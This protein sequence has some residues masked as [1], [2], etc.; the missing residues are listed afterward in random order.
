MMNICQDHMDADGL[1]LIKLLI[2][3]NR[4]QLAGEISEQ[5]ETKKT[6]NVGHSMSVS[7]R[8]SLCQTKSKQR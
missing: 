2:Q 7:Y 6:K 3:N 5:Y 8:R 4:L 1:N